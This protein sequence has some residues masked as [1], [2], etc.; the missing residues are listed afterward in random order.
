MGRGNPDTGKGAAQ[1]TWTSSPILGPLRGYV[2][3][4]T[5]YGESMID[6]DWNQNT[7]GIGVALNDLLDRP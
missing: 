7:V 4:F 5:G 1:F 2:S 6:Y 3:A